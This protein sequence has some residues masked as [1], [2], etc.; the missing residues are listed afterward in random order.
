MKH[1]P[2]DALNKLEEVSHLTKA[3]GGDKKEMGRFLK[4]EV[5]KKYAKPMADQKTYSAE[6]IERGR[7]MFP[8]EE[9]KQ[10]GEDGVAPIGLLQDFPS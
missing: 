8:K 4:M 6:Q 5:E 1:F 2:H 7:S 3:T 10:E 9:A